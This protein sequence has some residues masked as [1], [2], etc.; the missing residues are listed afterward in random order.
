MRSHPF[1]WTPL[2]FGVLFLLVLAGW[3]SL[4]TD[5]L[6]TDQ[7]RLAGPI[8]LIVLGLLGVALTFRR[9]K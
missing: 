6:T 3:V 2:V 4:E 5:L 1:A 9:K 8:A 7:V